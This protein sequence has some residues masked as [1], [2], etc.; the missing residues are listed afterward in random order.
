MR[1]AGLVWVESEHRNGG[2][3]Q[4]LRKEIADVE[5]RGNAAERREPKRNV[6]GNCWN[7]N[8]GGETEGKAVGEE[9]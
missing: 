5:E 3:P 6:R 9:K 1:V 4:G 8:A 2:G 7:E